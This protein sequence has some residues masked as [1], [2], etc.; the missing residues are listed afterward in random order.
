MRILF[1]GDASNY[2]RTLAV[3]LRHLGHEATVAS[4]GSRW[5]RTERDI[6]LSRRLPW[7]FGGL[8]LQMRLN[9]LASQ[10]RGYDVVQ[11]N[12]PIFVD[13]R[14]HRVKALFDRLKQENGRV[15]LTALG[16]DTAYM[17]EANSPMRLRYSEWQ[18]NGVP[19]PHAR[20]H[21][22]IRNAWFSAPLCT[23][24][25]YI[26]GQIDG[27]V[28]A[29]YEYHLAFQSRFT[30]ER[31]VYGGIPVDTDALSF[32]QSESVPDK[33]RMFIGLQRDRLTEK[34]T[35]RMLE[36]AKRIVAR[37][38]DKAEL[39]VVENRPYAEYIGL[40]QS[41]HVLLDQLYSYTPATNALIAMAYGLVAVSGGE[42]DYY[43]FIGEEENRPIVNALPDDDALES[44]LEQLVLHREMLPEMAKRSRQ[45][46]VKHNDSKVVAQRF[47]DFWNRRK[48]GER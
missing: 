3:A 47:I 41:S 10:M 21:S 34:G 39:V 14:P 25:E 44:Q 11:I 38:P 36:A 29:L 33:V 28:S 26:Y 9:R 42:D 1:V 32:S 35:D 19:T 48:E 12:N 22:E 6:D 2:H 7:K 15:Y 18:V 30:D 24:C 43:D 4:N 8:D 45:F 5:M 20:L 31:L 27:V 40:M 46:V 37:H 16:T 17:E 23:H 13:L